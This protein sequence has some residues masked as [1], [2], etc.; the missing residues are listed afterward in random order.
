VLAPVTAPR[1]V[2]HQRQ[3]PPEHA[4]YQRTL[5]ERDRMKAAQSRMKLEQA[6]VYTEEARRHEVARRAADG[7]AVPRSG[8][9]SGVPAGD[10]SVVSKFEVPRIPPFNPTRKEGKA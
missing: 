8:P 2:P 9:S 1:P 4:T 3:L 5:L 7:D 6:K 10:P